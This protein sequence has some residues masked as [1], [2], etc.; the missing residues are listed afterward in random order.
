M[1]EAQNRVDIATRQD[2]QL[3]VDSFYKRVIKDDTIGHFF[4]EVVVLNWEKHIPVMYDFWETTL[5]HRAI[6]QG[7]PI[8]VHLDLHHK[9]DLNKIHFDRWVSL[10]KATIDSYFRGPK[11]ELAKQR[12]MSIATIM[13]VKISQIQ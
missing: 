11:A 3:L 1:P 5:F 8:K 9:S 6:Y 4:T 7:N 13:Q 10:F 12:A 2:V